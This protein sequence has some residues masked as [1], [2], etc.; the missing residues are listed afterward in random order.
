[1]FGGPITPT[2]DPPTVVSPQSN[3][4]LYLFEPF[5]YTMP[6]GTFFDRDWNQTLTYSVSSLPSGLSFNSSTATI[7]GTPAGPG[8]WNITIT[9]ITDN[10]T[11]A[12]SVSNS[13]QFTALAP[14]LAVTIQTN[15]A[16]VNWPAAT[17]R[18]YLEQSPSRWVRTPSGLHSAC[19]TAVIR[20]APVVMPRSPSSRASGIIG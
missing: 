18:F 3:Q 7:S 17:Y 12:L 9:A 13:F 10:G 16:L 5:N 15:T 8:I 2:N 19:R 11:P 4:S 14:D 6:A 1:M 20:S